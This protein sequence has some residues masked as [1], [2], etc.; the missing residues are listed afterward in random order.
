MKIQYIKTFI[1]TDW[2][3]NLRIY[4]T[5][6]GILI[7]F[8][9]ENRKYNVENLL[10]KKYM[11]TLSIYY[12][13]YI[14]EGFYK[15]WEFYKRNSWFQTLNI[16]EEIKNRPSWY[17]YYNLN[18]WL[19]QGAGKLLG[20]PNFITNIVYIKYKCE[21]LNLKFPENIQKKFRLLIFSRWIKIKIIII[22]GMRYRWLFR[23]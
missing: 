1:S 4:A 2:I 19:N 10:E 14:E 23:I 9:I 22:Y 21:K 11:D 8:I 5:L 13:K 6:C 17:L 12:K 3:I 16:W 15:Y 18:F 7:F 20:G